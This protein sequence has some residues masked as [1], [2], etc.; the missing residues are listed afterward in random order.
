MDFRTQ[1]K[2]YNKADQMDVPRQRLLRF[3]N[4]LGLV[5][6]NRHKASV[7]NVLEHLDPPGRTE[8]TV[9]ITER[10]AQTIDTDFFHSVR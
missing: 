4:L 1:R 2:F 7:G 10:F 8:C 9:S 5:L 6:T 3:C